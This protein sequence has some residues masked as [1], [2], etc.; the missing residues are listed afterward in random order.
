MNN[1]YT[2]YSWPIQQ[3]RPY[4]PYCNPI[5]RCPTC[6]QPTQAGIFWQQGGL[7]NICS[8]SQNTGTNQCTHKQETAG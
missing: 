1:M 4:C 7:Q 8:S 6:G 3:Q 2:G 5:P